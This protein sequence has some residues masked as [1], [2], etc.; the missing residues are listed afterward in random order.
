MPTI[1]ATAHRLNK[2]YGSNLYDPRYTKMREL[3]KEIL[4]REKCDEGISGMAL[5]GDM[6]FALA[7]IELKDSGYNIKL[8]CAIPCQNQTLKWNH[9]P[10]HI[11]LYNYILSRADIVVTVTDKPYE[12][13]MMQVRNM[14]M[15]DK[16][17]MVIGVWNGTSG[18]TRN[19]LRYAVKKNKRIIRIIP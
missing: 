13:W 6:Q 2:L 11:K 10:E 5:G 18:G 1:C 19:C 7:I 9:L 15:V 12:E 14:Y 8:H 17:D 4:I 16:S 3:F